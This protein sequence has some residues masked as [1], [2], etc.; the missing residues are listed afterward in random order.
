MPLALLKQGQ[1]SSKI[2]GLLFLEAVVIFAG[3]TSSFWIEEWRQN[4]QDEDTYRH[5]LEEI[6]YNSAI[7]QGNLPL[8]IAGNNLALKDALELTVLDSGAPRQPDLYGRFDHIFGFGGWIGLSSA[9]YDRLS[10][11]PLSIP[12]DE[13]MVTLDNAYEVLSAYDYAVNS[14]EGEIGD[15]R[16]RYWR[17]AG[18]VSCT[19]AAAN[20]GSTILMDRPY[21]SEIRALLYPKG[22]C[23][24]QAENEARVRELVARPDFRNAVR[25]VIDLR[26]DIA[27]YIGEQGRMLSAIQAAIEDRLPG[28]GLPV[29]SM[30]LISWPMVTTVETERQTPMRKTGPH[31]WETSVE[32]TDGFIKF[33]ANENW[34]LNW[35]APFPDIID[36][37]AFLFNSD[38]VKVEDVFP[39]G[40]A[41]LTGM[42]L[43]VRAGSYRVTFNSRTREYAFEEVGSS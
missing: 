27:W 34:S 13:T 36:A 12:I 15:L 22:E 6:Y 39:S 25:Q 43:P 41:H 33:R 16:T 42:N 14:L 19:G 18:M 24:T 29:A 7:D 5:L 37:P 4:R 30:E 10:N 21:M 38:R 1:S 35:G 8:G 3:I 31:T 2:I 17:S 20:D 26:Q 23:I 40:T 11:T 32:L 28:I 9:G